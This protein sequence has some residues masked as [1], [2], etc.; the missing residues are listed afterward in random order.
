MNN[1][2][3]WV[4][5]VLSGW[6]TTWLT[7]LLAMIWILWVVSWVVASFWSGHTKKNVMSSDSLRY[8]ALIYLGAIL[9]L[10]LTGKVLGEQPLWQFGSSAPILG[11]AADGAAIGRPWPCQQSPTQ[12]R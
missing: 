12:T 5:F 4:A 2:G 8:R 10:P 6:T 7:Q 9:F 11:V 1:L 3:Q